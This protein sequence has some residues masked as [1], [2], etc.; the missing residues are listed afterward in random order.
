MPQ[1]CWLRF[2]RRLHLGDVE[3]R[4]GLRVVDLRGRLLIMHLPGD[5]WRVD[6][7]G[8]WL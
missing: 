6:L 1:V 4:G 5:L 2:N 8:P 7:R 3:L